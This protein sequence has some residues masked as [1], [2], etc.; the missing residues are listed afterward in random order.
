M[1]LNVYICIFVY[2]NMHIQKRPFCAYRY[3]CP[4]TNNFTWSQTPGRLPL[5]TSWADFT[6]RSCVA[7]NAQVSSDMWHSLGWWESKVGTKKSGTRN[8][9][10]TDFST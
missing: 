3:I 10:Y 6:A 9:V 5:R 4:N 7:S 2:V 1:D 8:G